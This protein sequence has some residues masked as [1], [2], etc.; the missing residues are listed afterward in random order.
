MITQQVPLLFTCGHSHRSPEQLVELLRTT[1]IVRLI[2]I[3]RYPV[4]R[5]HPHHA[6]RHMRLWIES[7][8]M[9]YRW[10]GGILGGYRAA[11]AKS[12]HTALD[13]ERLR[14]F[15]AH[16][17]GNAFMRSLRDIVQQAVDCPTALMC[18]ERLPERCHRA[19]VA[20]YLL[21]QGCR[22]VH[23]IEPGVAREHRMH[24]GVREID[25]RL[26]YN[27]ETTVPLDLR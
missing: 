5:R 7:A 23:L 8:G 14:G 18:A 2:D 20:D 16:M 26:V 15:A 3:R 6:R 25:G 11:V 4:S 22:V 19:L 27:R 12:S 13:D 10:E 9:H 17:A 24:P 21:W 1:G